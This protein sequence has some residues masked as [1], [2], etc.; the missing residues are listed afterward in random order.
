MIKPENVVPLNDR[1]WLKREVGAKETEEGIV[2]P[3]AEEKSTY[4]ILNVG[5]NVKDERLKPGVRVISTMFGAVDILGLDVP[6][7]EQQLYVLLAEDVIYA[8]VEE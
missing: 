6:K 8:I 7:E 4:T 3:S 2:L 1:L 5:P